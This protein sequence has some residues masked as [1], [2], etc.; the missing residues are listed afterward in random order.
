MQPIREFTKSK[1][2]Y[3]VFVGDEKHSDEVGLCSY[4]LRLVDGGFGLSM[5][6]K[7]FTATLNSEARTETL[8]M[9]Q[10]NK[11]EMNIKGKMNKKEFCLSSTTV[12]DEVLV[13][14][15][16][17]GD[18]KSYSLN[19]PWK[20]NV[21]D[22]LTSPFILNRI[23]SE[24]KESHMNVINTNFSNIDKC[25]VSQMEGIKKVLVPFGN[26]ECKV[27]TMDI[28][29]V[30]TKSFSRLGEILYC[31]KTGLMIKLQVGQQI[32]KLSRVK[33]LKN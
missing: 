21:F 20:G 15:S 6:N 14:Y 2:V 19:C 8:Y 10:I 3:Q 22:S 30:D 29:D 25:K 18:N 16:E 4:I 31:A 26:F 13:S 32:L 11:F 23:M 28:G 7:I 12:R 1:Y 5:E 17:G 33:V 24:K 27:F 9:P